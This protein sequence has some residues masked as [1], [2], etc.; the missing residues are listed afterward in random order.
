MNNSITMKSPDVV[1]VNKIEVTAYRR[2]HKI[3]WREEEEDW[4]YADNKKSIEDNERPCVAC[5]KMPTDEGHD[6]CI[7]NLP[8]VENACCGHG[9]ELGY[10]SFEDGTTIRGD[11]ARVDGPEG[12]MNFHREIYNA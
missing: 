9:V 5:G 7:A 11:F 12:I 3:I 2:G 4:V 8:G 6:P 10:I 1:K